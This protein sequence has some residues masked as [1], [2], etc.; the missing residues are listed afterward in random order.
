MTGSAFEVISHTLEAGEPLTS[1]YN[2]L[3]VMYEKTKTPFDARRE[4]MNYTAAKNQTIMDLTT[5]IQKLATISSK[6][7]IDPQLRKENCDTEACSTFIHCL[8]DKSKI[9]AIE[10]FNILSQKDGKPPT[11]IDFI[12][13]LQPYQNT[14]E[15]DLKKNGENKSN[16]MPNRQEKSHS[17]AKSIYNLDKSAY[18]PWNNASKSYPSR[19]NNF[20]NNKFCSLCG[21]KNHVAADGCYRMKNAAGKTVPVTPVQ[22]ACRICEK[23][24]KIR[25]FHPE[26]FCFNKPKR[27]TNNN[28]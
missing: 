24:N 7:T 6:L 16:K 9:L 8:P 13:Y 15:S 22:Q 1:I 25:L 23:K 19:K 17:Y 3:L 26:K 12:L 10:Q 20:L 18:K 2:R 5:E 4:L 27:P 14:I 21:F 11:F 28:S